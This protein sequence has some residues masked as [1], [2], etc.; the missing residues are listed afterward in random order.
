MQHIIQTSRPDRVLDDLITELG[1]LR[2]GHAPTAQK[3]DAQIT[4][5]T[6]CV[7]LVTK[8]EKQ[9]QRRSIGRMRRRSRQ[10]FLTRR[11]LI[12]A[13][14]EKMREDH[15][16]RLGERLERSTER[17]RWSSKRVAQLG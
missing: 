5:C 13:N 11:Q 3:W 1:N 8:R 17:L 9:R 14:I 2:V 16:T 7:R 6:N 10:Q 4:R 15:M 12:S